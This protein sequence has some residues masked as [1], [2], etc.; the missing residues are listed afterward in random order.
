LAA[1]AA[2]QLAQTFPA[3]LHL[4]GGLQFF[5]HATKGAT[6]SKVLELFGA[7]LAVKPRS[8][9][10]QTQA[11]VVVP[12]CAKATCL[13]TASS[14]VVVVG[15]GDYDDR[16]NFKQVPFRPGDVVLHNEYAGT[17][18]RLNGEDLILMNVN[19]V[20]GRLGDKE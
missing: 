14:E 17:G 15:D 6:M 1:L 12:D 3:T 7:R 10:N 13:D 4:S 20:I 18:F 5:L 8:A 19:E 16:G 9:P 11:G 2:A